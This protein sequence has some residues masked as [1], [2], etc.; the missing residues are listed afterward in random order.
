MKKLVLTS[1]L[2]V[3]IFG[4]A[5]AQLRWGTY[6]STTQNGQTLKA[7]NIADKD[8]L[9][10]DFVT[11]SPTPVCAW[12]KAKAAANL[13]KDSVYKKTLQTQRGIQV[14]A[15]INKTTTT[16][17][18][19]GSF[20][21]N[22]AGSNGNPGRV[23][24]VDSLKQYLI[25][26]V[27]G[28]V[29]GSTSDSLTRPA[30]C[31][32]DYGT[33]DVCF[34]MWP[35]KCTRIEYLYRF[36]Y[37]GKAC[38]DDI[39]FDMWTYDAGNSGKTATYT[40][41]VYSGST[42]STSNLIGDTAVIYTTGD[43]KKNVKLAETIGVSPSALSSKNLYV[44]IKTL[45]TN[46][47]GLTNPVD[48]NNIPTIYDPTVVFD[49]FIL[50][51]SASSW[52]YPTGA[53]GNAYINHNNGSPVVTTSTDWTG[54]TPVEIT[55]GTDEPVKMY[56]NSKDRLSTIAIT[57]SN[58]GGGHA[59]GFSFAETGAIKKNDGSGNYT[60][61]VAYTRAID[62]TT[63][64]YSI[65]VPAPTAGSANDD[66][67]ITILGNVNVGSTRAI[68]LELTNGVRFWY[69]VS[70]TAQVWTS[71][72]IIKLDKPQIWSAQ[73]NIFVSNNTNNIQ[74]FN[75]AG[76][77]VKVAT[78]KDAERGVAVNAGIYIIK[79]G[80]FVQKVIVE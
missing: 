59:A 18:E 12:A 29:N 30:A 32:F 31:F 46:N 5:F 7:I 52:S 23:A 24:S 28:G 53:V 63:G 16:A 20:K 10:L 39:T 11:V 72:E 47:D 45:G 61:D 77:K 49:N 36:D 70:I 64:K 42:Y 74:I 19:D 69:N 51:Y 13:G 62:E 75:V 17:Y 8:T 73:G 66:L 2:C 9:L 26:S 25:H 38:P 54:G 22:N 4:S 43:P 21:C 78:T 65:T 56:F 33:G 67:E 80:S 37:S 55:G 71:S 76:Q 15:F 68:R 14:K 41:E 60:I 79:A 27:T 44:V 50:M 48:A 3:L 40:V 57:E 6:T 35:G 34:G 58:D 1:L